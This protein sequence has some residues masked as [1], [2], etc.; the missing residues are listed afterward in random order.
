MRIR[1][2][3]AALATIAVTGLVACDFFPGSKYNTR[4]TMR[5]WIFMNPDDCLSVGQ[6]TFTQ[7]VTLPQFD[8]RS[9]IKLTPE[10]RDDRECCECGSN[11]HG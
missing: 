9:S 10:N 3:L 11:A 1:T 2:A 6:Y 8:L 5:T 7:D 4:Q